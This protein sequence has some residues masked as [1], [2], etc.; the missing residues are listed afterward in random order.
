MDTMLV[1]NNMELK[2]FPL[3]DGGELVCI[4]EAMLR[5]VERAID[6]AR[7]GVSRVMI[8]GGSGSGKGMVAGLIHANSAR[9]IQK[10]VKRNCASVSESLLESELFG[11][12]KGAFTGAYR[13]RQGAFRQANNGILFMDEVGD[14]SLE[15]QAKLLGVLDD[16]EVCP[17]GHDTPFKVNCHI[18]AATNRSLE[19]LV[20]QKKFRDDLYYRLAVH[21]LEIPLLRDRPRDILPLAHYFLKKACQKLKKGPIVLENEAEIMLMEFPWPGNVRQ[22]GNAMEGL[23]F[24]VETE[25]ASA[26]D[27]ARVLGNAE[28][29]ICPAGHSMPIAPNNTYV[30][31]MLRRALPKIFSVKPLNIEHLTDLVIFRKLEIFEHNI[32]AVAANLGIPSGRVR[33]AITKTSNI[34]PRQANSE[35]V[36]E[37]KASELN[38]N[39]PDESSDP[40][41]LDALKREEANKDAGRKRIEKIL[42]QTGGDI[43]KAAE[44]LGTPLPIF[45]HSLKVLGI[46]LEN[47]KPKKSDG[48]IRLCR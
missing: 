39:A 36:S 29:R 17:I 11:H 8:T 46:R 25:S 43:V 9:R 10:M 24:N 13:E 22:L 16:G 2:K 26:V 19:Q 41:I 37:I 45:Q 38:A 35:A 20:A 14:M 28:V 5:V 31:G 30:E 34:S 40:L 7:S 48:K 33:K 6:F 27:V 42:R 21:K 44:K 12:A 47:F 3:A 15:V 18:I 4:D 1:G 23:V 32:E